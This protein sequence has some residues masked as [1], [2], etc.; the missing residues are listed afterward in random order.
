MTI[1]PQL[2]SSVIVFGNRFNIEFGGETRTGV[3]AEAFVAWQRIFSDFLLLTEVAFG[4]CVSALA[5]IVGVTKREA[6]MSA[7]T[8]IDLRRTMLS[9]R[10][11]IPIQSLL[12][13]LK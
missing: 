5:V 10:I 9:F 2:V 11:S 7:I 3:C 13:V 12:V 4:F 1:S 8:A 6:K